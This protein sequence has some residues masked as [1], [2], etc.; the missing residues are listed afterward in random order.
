M[1]LPRH[2]LA[3]PQNLHLD[4][5]MRD[6]LP[7]KY[8]ISPTGWLGAILVAFDAGPGAGTGAG[9]GACSGASGAMDN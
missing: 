2:P 6:H 9:A 5:F 1:S 7:P 3:V 8:G 4:F